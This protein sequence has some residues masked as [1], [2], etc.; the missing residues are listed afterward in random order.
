MSKT[1]SLAN[2]MKHRDREMVP[3]VLVQAMFALMIAAVALVSYARLT[4]R[5]VT[6]VVPH[7]DIVREISVTLEGNR[8]EGV[9]VIDAD[10][11]EIAHSTQNKA[12]FIDV[13]W[14]SVM[15]ERT[16]QDVPSAA[17]VRIV[18]RENGHVAVIDDTTGWKIELIGYGQDNVA[19]FARLID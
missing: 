4:G 19:A 15:R 5:E 18:E 12:G 7:S 1:I 16:V 14:L 10:G 9:A 2:Q 8:S 3:K 11:K 17:P 6:S 13:V